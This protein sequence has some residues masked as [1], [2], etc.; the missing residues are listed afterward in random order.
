MNLGEHKQ[1]AEKTA[2]P[3]SPESDNLDEQLQLDILTQP[4]NTTCGPTC[5]HAIY[6]YLN[7]PLPLEQVIAET[8]KLKEGGTLAVWLGCHALRRSY[9]VTLYTFNLKVFDPSWFGDPTI[10]AD[11][12]DSLAGTAAATARSRRTPPPERLIERLEAQ[13][14]VK[15]SEKL[16]AASRAYIEFLQLGGEIRM[17][18]LNGN[19][20]RRYLKRSIPVLTGLCATYLY[21]CP[22]EFGPDYS[23]DDVRGLATGHFVVLCGYDRVQQKARVADPFRP[24]PFAKEHFY[25]VGFDRLVCA[26][27]LGILT[28]DANLLVIQPRHPGSPG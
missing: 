8:P 12:A 16:R 15:P 3:R 9:Q 18:D 5:L 11:A 14:A 13:M 17:E 7:D 10:L 28:H 19:L 2:R 22:R 23:A 25:E 6:R 20:I 21:G 1:P 24:N 4:D 27:L 26:I